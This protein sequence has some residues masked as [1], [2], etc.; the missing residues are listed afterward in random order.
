MKSSLALA[1]ASTVA[2]LSTS[3][4]TADEP[5]GTTNVVTD[6]G[7]GVGNTIVLDNDGPSGTTI[8]RNVRNGVGNKLYVQQDGGSDPRVARRRGRTA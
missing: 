2:L 3:G 6:S 7:N 8:L 1:L 5:K 4:L